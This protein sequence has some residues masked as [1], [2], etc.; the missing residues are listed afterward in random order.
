MKN[1][2]AFEERPFIVRDL[3]NPATHKRERRKLYFDAVY[4]SY[5]ANGKRSDNG[6]AIELHDPFWKK[7]TRLVIPSVEYFIIRQLWPE[8]CAVDEK[9]AIELVQPQVQMGLF[10]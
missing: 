10:S 6:E 3:F 5:Y 7:G 4:P 2:N 9:S 8:R 1:R